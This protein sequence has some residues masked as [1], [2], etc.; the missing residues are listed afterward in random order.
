M[1]IM[2]YI[3]LHYGLITKCNV[4]FFEIWWP[5]VLKTTRTAPDRATYVGF[6]GFKSYI[7]DS[8]LVL[9]AYDSMLQTAITV[10][11]FL[12]IGNSESPDITFEPL[13]LKEKG[14]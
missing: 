2:P 7:G 13:K 14:K 4:H 6:S 3:F 5:F 10:Q 8:L 9:R 1:F 11:R 12:P